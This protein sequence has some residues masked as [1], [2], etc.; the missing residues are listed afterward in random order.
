MRIRI[1]ALPKA[2]EFEEFDLRR[3]QVGEVY[4][5]PPQMASLLI[6]SG[7]ADMVAPRSSARWE[8]ADRSGRF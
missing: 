8:A 3:Y 1:T 2:D 7:Y 6:L 4:D 5:V